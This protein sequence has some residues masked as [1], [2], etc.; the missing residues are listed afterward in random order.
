M[1]E[2]WK[3]FKD[4]RI[5]KNGRPHSKGA[6]WEVSDQGNVKR[7]GD[8]YECKLNN[9]GYKV[10]PGCQSVHRAVAKLFVPNPENKPCVDHINGDKL[11]NRACNLRW[12]S[13]KENSNNPITLKRLSEATKIAVNKEE[14]KRKMSK[15]KKN[16]YKEHPE[17]NKGE[18]NPMYGRHRVY[19]DDGTWYMEKNL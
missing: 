8:L 3:V 10:L 7:N 2:I 4:T 19:H 1:G 9:R 6:L 11:D 18:N 12:V 16:W 13:Y 15:S 14:I 5:R 17:F